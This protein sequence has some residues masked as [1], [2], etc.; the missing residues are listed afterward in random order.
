[1][2]L[3]KKYLEDIT[4]SNPNGQTAILDGQGNRTGEYTETFS[5]P[6]TVKAFVS[7]NNGTAKLTGFGLDMDYDKVCMIADKNCNISEGSK[8]THKG[9]EYLVKKIFDAKC[10]SYL[11]IGMNEVK[12][13]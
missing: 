13:Q 8:V 5:S 11:P 7:A 12:G 10:L 2:G 6:I 1:M 3:S 4:F 9:T